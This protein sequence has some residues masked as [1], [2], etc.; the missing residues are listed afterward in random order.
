VQTHSTFLDSTIIFIC[1]GL[2]GIL[3]KKVLAYSSTRTSKNVEY[4]HSIFTSTFAILFFGTPHNATHEGN[5]LVLPNAVASQDFAESHDKVN[6]FPQ[7][8][9]TPKHYK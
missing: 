4:L 6:C 9:R 8:R 1:H 5:W 3:V 7:L 2:G